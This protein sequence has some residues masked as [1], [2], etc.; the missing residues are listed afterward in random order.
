MNT[1]SSVEGGL[2]RWHLPKFTPVKSAKRLFLKL[3]RM[4]GVAT[5][6]L[7]VTIS[8]LA[9]FVPVDFVHALL[10]NKPTHATQTVTKPAQPHVVK[11]NVAAKPT[12]DAT[13]MNDAVDFSS[14]PS[15]ILDYS[16]MANGSVSDKYLNI[17]VGHS[18]ANDEAQVYTA[19]TQNVRI[20]NG[21]LVL[22]G[23]ANNQSG[24]R[25]T[26]GKV[27]TRG[28]EDFQYG[29]LVVRAKLPAG[30]G[31][32]PAIWMLPS[33]SDYS[34]DNA[35]SAGEIDITEAVGFQPGV[36][37]SVAHSQAYDNNGVDRTFFNTITIPDYA[38][39]FHDYEMDWTP[40][41]LSFKVDG[42]TYFTYTKRAGADAS[43]WPYDQPFY[44]IMNLAIG[45]SWGGADRKDFPADGIDSQA[46]PAALRI[47]SVHYYSYIGPK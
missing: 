24:A 31:T 1:I 34:R 27:D 37:Y 10:S 45:G 18:V 43:T 44:L 33:Q 5:I 13:D 21:N 32:W 17:S 36:I 22:E 38:Q 9:M 42:T 47:Q 40:T 8:C 15:F 29:K 12:C 14:C 41:T 35:L 6:A 20:E 30:V 3:Y 2:R 28:K 46:F 16:K 19:N 11:S 25:Y 4:F 7:G 39:A 26:S 23:Q